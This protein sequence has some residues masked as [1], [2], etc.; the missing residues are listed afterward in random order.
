[1][2]VLVGC[3]SGDHDAEPD[4]G[5][6]MDAGD[7]LGA[8][9]ESR[10]AAKC[11]SQSGRICKGLDIYHC[12][13]GEIAEF[14]ESCPA[15]GACS[16]GRCTS[17][18]CA[19]IEGRDSLRGCLFY[20]VQVD[21]IDEDDATRMVLLVSNA[22][23]LP[24][25]V[26]VEARGVSDEMWEE[27]MPAVT[28]GS[29]AGS[30]LT[31]NRPVQEVGK[32]A[33]AAL[34]ITSDR[35]IIAAQ[36]IN[37]NRDHDSKSS[38]ATVLLP[39]QSLRSRYMALTYPAL[40]S[41]S[42]AA[43]PGGRG[44][45]GM[46]VIVGTETGG[47]VI[48][49]PTAAM[50]VGDGNTVE[51][52][53]EYRAGLNDGDVLQLFS[54]DPNGDLTGTHIEATSAV[55]VFSGNVFT[56]YGQDPSGWNGADLAFE[57]MPPY[58]NWGEEYVGAFHSPQ[59]GCDS[60]WG[61]T[62]G[63]WQVLAAT[64]GT[65]VTLDP[66]PGT[67]FWMVDGQPFDGKQ[68]TLKRGESRRFLALP[69]GTANPDFI[70]RSNHP[71]RILL[72]QWLDCEPAL[73]WGIDTR[74]DFG[75]LA[76]VLPPGFDNEVLVARRVGQTG[77]FVDGKELR[78]ADF[79][80]PFGGASDGTDAKS[81]IQ[82]ARVTGLGAD[83]KDLGPCAVQEDR[84]QHVIGDGSLGL[85][86]RGMDVTCSFMLTFPPASLCGSDTTVCGTE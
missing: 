25:N 69:Q 33:S 75:K 38:G 23:G 72:A 46:I 85:S 2:T 71:H 68:F 9:D 66:S 21:N 10:P 79:G 56:S 19:N 65:V 18:E 1:M 73:A 84:C 3:R 22:S 49:K 53:G 74:F 57:Q 60:Y 58:E 77:S 36:L 35:P 78:S 76:L 20:S 5:T 80:P 13:G 62:G 52:G 32:V 50:D 15:D 54:A 31:V 47:T 67:V 82:I 51:V 59:R 55:A 45:A 24:A 16:L 81:K 37:E 4:L 29:P 8:P 63:M 34:R 41:A 17:V 86:W 43:T 26:A 30:R 42:V 7:D 14:I 70:A 27:V 39:A 6:G 44:G 48:V 64:D 40:P 83:S 12:E 28:V 11:S 61:G